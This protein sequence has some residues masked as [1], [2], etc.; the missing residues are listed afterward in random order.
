MRKLLIASIFI[1]VFSI[2]THAQFVIS[3]QVTDSLGNTLEGVSVRILQTSSGAITNSKGTFSITLNQAGRYTFEFTHLGYNMAKKEVLVNKDSTIVNTILSASVKILEGV[4][5][6]TEAEGNAVNSVTIKSTSLENL[7]APF[8]DITNALVSLPSVVSN[9]EL[10][11]SYSVRG[12]NYDE[13][14]VR[15]NGFPVYRP[16]LVRA[17]QQ[18]GLSFINNDLVQSVEFSAGGWDAHY[19]GKMSSLL[20]ADYKKASG[21]QGGA[22]LS[23]LG[24]S[25]YLEGTIKDASFIIGARHKRSRYLLNSLDINGQYDPRFTDIQNFFPFQ[26]KTAQNAVFIFLESPKVN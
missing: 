18:E 7:S 26:Q 5:I 4:N 12:G 15:V 21:W 16:F 14:M 9:N 10:S 22:S 17:G 6:E 20:L 3:G 25:A 8:N 2:S 23:F 1:L 13:N 19:G 11:S 24:G